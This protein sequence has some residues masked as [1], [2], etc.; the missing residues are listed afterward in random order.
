M[1]ICCIDLYTYTCISRN[2]VQE[3]EPRRLHEVNMRKINDPRL[4]SYFF[5]N[6]IPNPYDSRLKK[7]YEDF[8]FSHEL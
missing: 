2:V 6:K 1:D 8:K 3:A 4:R 7:V 5:A